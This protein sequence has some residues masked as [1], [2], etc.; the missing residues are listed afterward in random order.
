[1]S[2]FPPRAGEL[3]AEMGRHGIGGR[4][5]SFRARDD[6]AQEMRLRFRCQDRSEEVVSLGKYHEEAQNR[7]LLTYTDIASG[8]LDCIPIHP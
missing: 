1:M 4:H 6:T 8:R 2:N 7:L 5:D 3:L